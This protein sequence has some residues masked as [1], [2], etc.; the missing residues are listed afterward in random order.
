[1]SATSDE[2]QQPFALDVRGRV[3]AVTP[4]EQRPVDAAA[5]CRR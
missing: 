5:C 1:M 2:T 4:R 3:T